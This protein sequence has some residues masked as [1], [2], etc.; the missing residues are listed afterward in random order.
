MCNQSELIPVITGTLQLAKK[1]K[2]W[3]DS[4]FNHS[5]AANQPKSPTQVPCISLCPLILPA[6]N[7]DHNQPAYGC[8]MHKTLVTALPWCERK[9]CPNTLQT[10]SCW[11]KKGHLFHSLCVSDRL[12]TVSWC[13]KGCFLPQRFPLLK[14]N[15]LYN[16]TGLL[17][18]WLN[19]FDGNMLE[20]EE[21]REG[22]VLF[23]LLDYSNTEKEKQQ[24]AHLKVSCE[25]LW[26]YN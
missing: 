12:A 8:F 14:E 1:E 16:K 6:Y 22:F 19:V 5:A 9:R 20:R 2:L 10:L 18:H 25:W 7:N 13:K 11:L 17:S 21:H 23:A 26:E 3:P 4:S 15:L 24:R